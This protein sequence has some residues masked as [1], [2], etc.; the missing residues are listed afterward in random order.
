MNSIEKPILNI[1]LLGFFLSNCLFAGELVLWENDGNIDTSGPYQSSAIGLRSGSTATVVSDPLNTGRGNVVRFN[2]QGANEG[3][4]EWA[5]LAVSASPFGVPS[6][7]AR[8][9]DSRIV[10]GDVPFVFDADIHTPTN[11]T[12]TGAD[13]A[14]VILRFWSSQNNNFEDRIE[15]ATVRYTRG[16]AFQWDRMRLRGTIPLVDRAGNPIDQME[17]ILSVADFNEDSG[18]GT[19]AYIDNIRLS[20]RVPGAGV[21]LPQGPIALNPGTEDADNDGLFDYWENLFGGQSLSANQDA[22]GDGQ[23]NRQESLAGT[24]PFN[25]GDFLYLRIE[26]DGDDAR[27]SWPLQ[28]FR[29]S[30]IETS[31]TLAGFTSSATNP[32]VINGENQMRISPLEERQFYRLRTT[33]QDNDNDRVPDYVEATI[34][35]RTS[36]ANSSQQA[37]SYDLNND[38]IAE[39]TISG[40]LATYNE[41]YRRESLGT[42]PTEAQAARFLMQASFAPTLGEIRK[43]QDIGYEAW[44]EEQFEL[45][46]FLTIDPIQE[47]WEDWQLNTSNPPTN[48]WLDGYRPSTNAGGFLFGHEFMNAWA[49]A[50]LRADDSLRQRVA[51]ALNQILVASR[52]D[53]ALTNSPRAT[54]NYYDL[55][56]K[57]AF[58][59]YRDLLT[60]VTLSPYM[61]VYLSYLGNRKA[62]PSIGRFPD[63][64][65]AREVMQLFTIGLFELNNDGTRKL[66]GNGEP[67]ETYDTQDI[68]EYARVFTGLSLNTDR[69]ATQPIFRNPQALSQRMQIVSSEHDFGQKNLLRGQVIPARSQN[70]NNGLQDIADTLQGLFDHP[71]APPFICRQLIQF[72]VTSNPS[73]EYVNRVANVFINNGEG[74]RGDLKA[75]VKAILLDDEARNPSEHLEA[76]QFGYLREPVIRYMHLAK[77][78]KLDRFPELHWW[79]FGAYRNE[80]LQEPMN[81]PTVFNFYRPD[82]RHFGVLAE[83]GFDSPVFGIVDGY[84]SISFPNVLWDLVEDGF[85]YRDNSSFEYQH[86]CDW[87]DL[88]MF[89][90]DLD[91]LLDRVSLLFTAGTMNASTR[92]IIRGQLQLVTNSTSRAR[93][94]AYL[95]IMSPEGAALK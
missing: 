17:P 45:P 88:V 9:W 69:I 8:V 26:Q 86:L 79:D 59:N 36:S 74:D 89:S 71:N 29:T 1:T 65:F 81:S 34:N 82:N 84:S 62:N 24:D 44:I 94:A 66:D 46:M 58:G 18:N 40:D 11:G 57:N 43:V 67:I 28:N 31:N 3:G 12:L 10:T 55:M 35:T 80:S 2:L 48:S 50:V 5:G 73:P 25:L 77:I 78:A 39:T 15:W 49:R 92:D 85:E 83:N 21:E 13:G 76:V 37:K 33:A 53:A 42:R 20:I 38:G 64:N 22:D 4:T 60:D 51:F 23:T 90:N 52:A 95:A 41:V 6:N 68:T 27:L 93:L 47:I 72:L 70:D 7:S 75:V 32:V 54:A 63:E 61:G 87:T 30:Q 91:R 16:S 56:V 14:A 19:F